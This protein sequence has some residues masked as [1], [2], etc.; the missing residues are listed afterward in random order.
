MHEPTGP[1]T[2][3]LDMLLGLFVPH[4]ACKTMIDKLPLEVVGKAQQDI[5][6][7]LVTPVSRGEKCAI[8]LGPYEDGDAVRHLTCNHAFHAEVRFQP[9]FFTLTDIN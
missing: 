3:L 6:A 4:G 5:E 7:G 1:L 9:L 2:L 8:C